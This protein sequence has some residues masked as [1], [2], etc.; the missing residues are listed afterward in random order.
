MIIEKVREREISAHVD[1]SFSLT[2]PK[3]D[4]DDLHVKGADRDR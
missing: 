2:V 3:F 4:P 1:G